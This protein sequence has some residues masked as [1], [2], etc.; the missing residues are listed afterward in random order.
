[1]SIL[2]NIL[3]F[4]GGMGTCLVLLFFLSLRYRGD[5]KTEM[6]RDLEQLSKENQQKRGL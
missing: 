3:Y 5:D 6:L 4:L 1:V 2:Y